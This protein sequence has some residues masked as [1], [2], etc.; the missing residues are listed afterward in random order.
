MKRI[1]VHCGPFAGRHTATHIAAQLDNIVQNLDNKVINDTQTITYCTS[2]NAANMLAAIPS[3]TQC[4]DIGFGC[5]DHKL[6]IVVNKALESDPNIT[7]GLEA[8]KKLVA[9]THKSSLDQQ[10][11]KRECEKITADPDNDITVKYVKI[12]TSVET[13]WNSTLMMIKSILALQPALESIKLDNSKDL[14]TKQPNSDPKLQAAMPEIDM[15]EVSMS[16]YR[17]SGNR[18]HTCNY[19]RE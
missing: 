3:K 7:E 1:L 15:F 2:D 13:R 14:D 6:Q 18:I 4:I 9:R 17:F 8:F 5:L 10:R 12:I 19:Y 11:I 16:D